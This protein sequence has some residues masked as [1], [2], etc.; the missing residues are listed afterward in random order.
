MKNTAV[1]VLFVAL[2]VVFNSSGCNKTDSTTNPGG[3]NNALQG[4]VSF[5]L[6]GAGF[7]NQSFSISGFLGG[8]STS[9][10]MTGLAGSSATTGDS[11]MLELVFPGTS[12]G[13]FSFFADSTGVAI[14][15]GTGS[16]TRAFVSG[17]G[18]GQ[19]VVTSYGAVG[20]SIVGTFSGKLY[21]VKNTGLDSVTVS[22]GSFN[23]MRVH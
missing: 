18:G 12:T 14:S 17:Q 1:C 3:N 22:N 5:T 8:Y 21:E 23:A 4:S 19:I 7:T 16:S 10:K 15:R 13:T 9:D 11:T 20:G 6:N 2:I